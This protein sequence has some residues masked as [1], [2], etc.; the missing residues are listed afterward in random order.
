MD[1]IVELLPRRA[2]ARET[3]AGVFGSLWILR[4]VRDQVSSARVCRL[5]FSEF[6]PLLIVVIKTAGGRSYLGFGLHLL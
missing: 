3:L 6:P 1:F 4:R 2:A 5:E